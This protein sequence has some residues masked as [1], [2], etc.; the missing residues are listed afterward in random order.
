MHTLSK[1]IFKNR[2]ILVFDD[3]KVNLLIGNGVEL[4]HAFEVEA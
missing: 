3:E 1:K 2:M 4:G